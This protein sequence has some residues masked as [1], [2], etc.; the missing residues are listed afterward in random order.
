LQN[1][2]VTTRGVCLHTLI[3]RR[4]DTVVTYINIFVHV[5]KVYQ[6]IYT[7]KFTVAETALTQGCE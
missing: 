5:W 3:C 4:Y 1:C 6:L 7:L 2:D